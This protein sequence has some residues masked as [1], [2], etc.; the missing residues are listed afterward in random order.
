MGILDR[1][2]AKK[3][4]AGKAIAIGSVRESI[5]SK[6]RNDYES[7][8][9]TLRKERESMLD[10]AGTMQVYVNILDQAK[11]PE[12]TYPIIIS[13][14]NVSRKNF[15]TKM[16]LLISQMKKP[17]GDDMDSVLDFYG[18]LG[19]MIDAIN[20][21]TIKDYAFLKMLFEKEGK[22][23]VDTFR[24][25][26][27]SNARIQ[28]MLK[29]IRISKEQMSKTDEVLDE[30][31]NISEELDR[32]DL[33]KMDSA[34]VERQNDLVKVEKDSEE[35][36]KG[37]EWKG[38]VGLQE[39]AVKAKELMAAKRREFERI[40][41]V[42]EGPL[43]RY[44]KFA[45]SHILDDYISKSFDSVICE[46]P[47]GERILVLLKNVNAMITEGKME[48]KDREQVLKK[49]GELSE[50][51]A[52]GKIIQEYLLACEE[53]K[54]AT[55]KA[56]SSQTM[57]RKL[58]LDSELERLRKQIEDMKSDRKKTE[59]IIKTIKERKAQK[60]DQLEEILYQ[61]F[62]KRIKIE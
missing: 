59:E 16:N 29:G 42:I 48:I 50:N 62:K 33:G 2:F 5:S 54:D 13:K 7:I 15:I 30:I 17:L 40:V 25:I 57:K 6:I 27:D 43:K 38:I 8:E 41:D 51:N 61:I 1:F 39:K 36:V 11:Y 52:I 46:D 34:I 60:T 24:Q 21:E 32:D 10:L 19:K 35:L 28:E 9:G 44:K 37:D 22:D 20:S 3:E 49:I 23:V 4:E 47:R 53:V 45:G 31:S 14:S 58:G 26:S 12:R 18:N 55:E 56:S